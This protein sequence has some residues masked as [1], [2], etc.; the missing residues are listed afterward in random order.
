M[1]S[2]RG[3]KKGGVSTVQ[4][5]QYNS[6]PIENAFLPMNAVLLLRENRFSSEAKPIVSEGQEVKEG[7]LIARGYEIGR[8]HV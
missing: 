2:I 5:I 6:A 4:R 3:F 7:Q 8:A 1:T